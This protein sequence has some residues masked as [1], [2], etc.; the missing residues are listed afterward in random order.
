MAIATA[1]GIAGLAMGAYGTYSSGQA[2]KKDAEAQ[3]ALGEY[4]AE[5]AEKDAKA[6]ELQ[7]QFEQFRQIKRGAKI[8]GTTKAGLGASG[9]MVSEGAPLRL[10]AEQAFELELENALIGQQG[11]TQAA[12]YRSD[13]TAYRKGAQMSRARGS[14]AE[15]AGNLNTGSTILQG[16]G[17]MYKQGMFSGSGG[18]G[19]SGYATGYS[20]TATP[21]TGRF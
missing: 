6:T 8:A 9:A 7:T 1:I 10:M 11:R 3:A 5:V 15:T 21:G 4:N 2:G 18:G 13:A 19:G 14:A 16:F 20:A 17:S 12:R